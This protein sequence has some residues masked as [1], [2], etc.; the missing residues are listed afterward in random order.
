MVRL[1]TIAQAY[2]DIKE[3][4]KNTSV[5]QNYIRSLVNNGE[6]PVKKAGNKALINM[7]FLEKYLTQGGS[8]SGETQ[9]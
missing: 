6:I 9:S 4:D 2:A 5:T 1:R 3:A 7:D 8:S